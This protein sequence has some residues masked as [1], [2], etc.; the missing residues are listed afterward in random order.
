[1]QK[2]N[3]IISLITL[4]CYSC[5]FTSASEYY[6]KSLVYQEQ[7]DLKKE[8]EFLEKALEK[9]P[10]FRPALFNHGVINS[11]VGNY[12]QAIADYQ[13]I[14]NFDPENTQVLMYIGNNY[15]KLQNFKK[16][17]SYY[18]KAIKTKGALKSDTI[19]FER[20]WID[21]FDKDN[22]Y[23]IQKCAI[24]FQR[25][26]A[27][28]NN[29][30]YELAITDF[31]STIEADYKKPNSYYWIGEANIELKDSAEIC[32]NFNKSAQLGLKEAK[33]KLKKYCFKNQ[34]N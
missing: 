24:V 30:Q 26:L 16:A 3:I 12:E 27:Y 34:P 33:V 23:Y 25:G 22:E 31:R 6:L 7:G 28:M 32:I 10:K 21:K 18:N 29:S 11:T 8:F 5:D 17:I 13:K 4:I 14:I 2:K 19:S 9:N 1:M 20:K 15:T